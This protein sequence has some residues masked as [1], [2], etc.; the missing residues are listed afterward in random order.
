LTSIFEIFS[1]LFKTFHV[2]KEIRNP[3]IIVPMSAK[4]AFGTPS[5]KFVLN[6]EG[7]LPDIGD[8]A[9]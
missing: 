5:L 2:S 4:I 1:A 3:Q 9:G 6:A 7:V 8:L